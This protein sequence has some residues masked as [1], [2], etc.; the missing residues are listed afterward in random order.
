M[1]KLLVLLTAAAI[2]TV[3]CGTSPEPSGTAEPEN[4]PAPVSEPA[5]S[6]GEMES[7]GVPSAVPSVPAEEKEPVP[8]SEPAPVPDSD[9]ADEPKPDIGLSA[10]YAFVWDM[11]EEAPVRYETEDAGPLMPASITKLL[12]IQ[13][14]L[15]LM[16]P[17]TLI[18]PGDEV[19]F[20]PEGSSF[21]YIRPNHTLT[22]EMLIEGMLLPSG[23]DAAY[24]AAAAGGR[25]LAGDNSL[26]PEEAVERFVDGM[27]GYAESLGCTETRFTTPDGFAGEEHYSSTADMARIAKAAAENELI[28]RYAG[29]HTDDVTYASGHTNTWTNTN[30][31]LNPDSDYYNENVIGLK[32]GS[33]EDNFCLVT[34]YDDGE[35]QLLLGVF[36]CPD[37]TSRYSDTQLLLEKLLDDGE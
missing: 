24:A 25:V 37:K 6:A 30:A 34:L 36:G 33:T 3:S 32:T 23:N 17:D 13:Y 10:D 8:P 14:A 16:E 7:P 28:L 15:T 5:P 2:L 12:T 21:A 35:T 11:S 18:T 19:Y 27:N 9:P 31:F 26:S 1:K 4:A 22:L 20:P 29:L